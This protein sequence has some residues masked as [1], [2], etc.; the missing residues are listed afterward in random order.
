MITPRWLSAASDEMM[1]LYA[2]L[3]D[4]I[5]TDMCRRMARLGRISDSTRWQAKILDEAGRLTGD[6][7]KQLAKYDRRTQKAVAVL[8]KVLVTKNTRGP[9]SA[10]QRQLLAAATGYKDLVADLSN[11]TKTSSA[12][13][14]F[15]NAATNLYMQT[16]SGAFS[17]QDAL[18]DAV[19][20]MA[21]K[22]LHT[23]AYG[24]REMSV[25]AAARMCVLTTLNQTAAEQSIQNAQDTETNLVMVSAH[26]GA[27]HTDKPANPW[28]NHDEWQGKVYCLSGVRTFIDSDGQEHTAQDFYAVTGYGEVDG[29]CGIN[30][31][32]T[33]WPYYEGGGLRYDDE[34]LKE[35]RA[36]NLELDGKKVSRYEAEQ[37]LRKAERMIRGWKRRAECESAAGLD[38]TAAR[39]RLGLW[40][41]RRT[42]VCD[43]TGISPDYAR[44]YI[45]VPDGKQ[46]RGIRP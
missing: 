36:K 16:A 39:M 35:Y 1:R 21:A 23:I 29:L 15:V 17:Y 19:D 22:G 31:R 5:K 30:C 43:Q 10:N 20:G 7:A 45:G 40:Q 18:K 32:H 2:D 38:D 28:S 3:E 42:S 37:E 26:E 41:A 9:L 25:E 27:R 6:I 12:V 33:F 14:D 34:E 8:F 13:T 24:T 4:A 11:I 44:E 46:P